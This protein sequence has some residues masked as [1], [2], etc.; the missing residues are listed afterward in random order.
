MAPTSNRQRS[1]RVARLTDNFHRVSEYIDANRPD[2][3]VNSACDDDTVGVSHWRVYLNTG[4]GFFRDR[5]PD[6]YGPLVED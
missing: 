1:A 4:M 3:V 2:L 5:R 6:A